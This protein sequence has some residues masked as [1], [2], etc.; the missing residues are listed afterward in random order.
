MKDG[1]LKSVEMI[2]PV[3]LALTDTQ[4][5]LV[6]P[7]STTGQ[8]SFS[9]DTIFEVNTRQEVIAAAGIAAACERTTI[10]S[11]GTRCE[12]NEGS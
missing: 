1:H 5:G 10:R 11:S 6:S 3:H 7:F 9:Q 2:E 12:K 4:V 8:K